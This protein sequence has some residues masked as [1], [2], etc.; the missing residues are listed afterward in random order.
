MFQ[1]LFAFLNEVVPLSITSMAFS[2]AWVLHLLLV[3]IG[4]DLLII[5]CFVT[6]SCDPK[7]LWDIFLVMVGL[8][9]QSISPP[10]RHIQ[11]HHDLEPLGPNL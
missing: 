8:V 11:Q 6:S 4:L 7:D 1:C 3:L 5:C 2:N 9:I 10:M